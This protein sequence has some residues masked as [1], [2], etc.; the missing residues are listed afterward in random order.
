[1]DKLVLPQSQNQTY[2]QT[3]RAM[4]SYSAT[5]WRSRWEVMEQLLVQ[6]GDV[7]QFLQKEDLGSPTTRAKLLALITDPSAC[8][9]LVPR[10]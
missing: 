9:G 2:E 6:F 4:S 10:L 8:E 5:R 7:Q 1:M 3:G